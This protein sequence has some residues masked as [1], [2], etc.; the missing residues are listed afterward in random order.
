M[1]ENNKKT[2][3]GNYQKKW[4]KEKFDA[5][6]C[7]QLSVNWISETTKRRVFPKLISMMNI[8][9]DVVCWWNTLFSEKSIKACGI[10]HG[11]SDTFNWSEIFRS[12]T[13]AK[14]FEW[15]KLKAF[16][17]W[18]RLSWGNREREAENAMGF[19]HSRGCARDLKYKFL[20]AV[21]V[22]WSFFSWF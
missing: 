18:L 8:F 21:E 11:T 15:R 1:S 7:D 20:I 16:L 10:C 14:S 19:R 13:K 4:K 6:R 17:I 2:V 9:I 22:E 5:M 12:Q 3:N